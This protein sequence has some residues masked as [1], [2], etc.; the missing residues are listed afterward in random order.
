MSGSDDPNPAAMYQR[1]HKFA[2]D[3][4]PGK[5]KDAQEDG[6]CLAA[7]GKDGEKRYVF[8][9]LEETRISMRI[10]TRLLDGRSLT[11]YHPLYNFW[12]VEGQSYKVLRDEKRG[13]I[14]LNFRWAARES[15][16]LN[17][18]GHVMQRS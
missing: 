2:R 17:L 15:L 12:R 13:Y 6:F 7:T 16:L 9:K 18:L 3:A 8:V 11:T 5:F 10:P 4:Y 14:K 1:V